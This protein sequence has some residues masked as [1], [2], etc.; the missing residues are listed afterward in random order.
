[1]TLMS[2][3]RQTLTDTILNDLTDLER[4]KALA[5]K[6][7][8]TLE[9]DQIAACIQDAGLPLAKN[10][11]AIYRAENILIGMQVDFQSA[12][13]AEYDKS[14][15]RIV[16]ERHATLEEE[17]TLPELYTLM[18]ENIAATDLIALNNAKQDSKEIDDSCPF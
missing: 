8:V 3:I 15:S 9:Y 11:E 2:N 10:A 6:Y 18:P 17:R 5:A 14:I 12:E 7:L 1:M 4:A 13:S 16:L